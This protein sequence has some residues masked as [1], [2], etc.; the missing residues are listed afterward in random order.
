MPER[1][2][3]VGFNLRRPAI[4]ATE[5]SFHDDPLGRHSAELGADW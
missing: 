2:D 4:D 1:L 5:Y 3:R